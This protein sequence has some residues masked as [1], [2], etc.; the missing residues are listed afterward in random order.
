MLLAPKLLICVTQ[1]RNPVKKYKKRSEE[2][3]M[4]RLHLFMKGIA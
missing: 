2:K 4:D 3:V 1:A